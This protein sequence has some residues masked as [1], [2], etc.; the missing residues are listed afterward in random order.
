MREAAEEA[1]TNVFACVI[2]ICHY[3]ANGEGNTRPRAGWARRSN[4]IL[5]NSLARSLGLLYCVIILNSIVLSLFSNISKAVLRFLL[6]NHQ[7]SC[8][9]MCLTFAY[10][11]SRR[12]LS[13][14][15]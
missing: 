1:I 2:I 8:A 3:P 12:Y 4:V 14:A 11:V 9:H 7:V 6:L 5:D 10:H 13:I 15:K